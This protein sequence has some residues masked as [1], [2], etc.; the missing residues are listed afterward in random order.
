MGAHSGSDIVNNGLVFY[1]DMN[2]STK[3][4]KGQPTTN[5][6]PSPGTNGRFTT[7][8]TW[9]TYNTGLY[10][11][12]AYFSIGTIA[13]V[14]NN[15][16]TTTTPHIFNTFDAVLPETTGGGVTAGTVY[17]VKKISDTEF[18]LHAYNSSQD[19]S[20]GYINP[21]TG[22][23][24]VH[25]SIALDQRIAVNATSFPTSWW[26]SA[27]LPNTCHVKEV[28]EGG[29]YEKNTNCMRI[30]VTRTQNISG[31]MS[32]GVNT[33]ATAGDNIFVSFWARSNITTSIGYT[34]YFGPGNSTFG[35]TFN[36]SP[37]WQKIVFNWTASATYDFI[38]YF[39]PTLDSTPYYIDIADIQVEKNVQTASPFT[40]NTRSN[41]QAI[42]DVSGQGNTATATS[43]TYNA[44]GTFSFN[45]SSN[46]IST[47]FSSTSIYAIDFWMYN[48]NAIIGDQSIGGPSTYQSPINF[49]NTSTAG[50]NLGGWTGS[51]TQEKLHIW[52]NN[53]VNGAGST[54]TQDEV[55]AGW[56]H[57]VFN[58]NG[59]TYDIWMDGIKRNTYA[60]AT[61]GHAKL[62]QNITVLRAGADAST[63]YYFHGELPAVKLYS[64]P[65]TDTEVLQNFNATRSLY[66]I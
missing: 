1:Y 20:Q 38:Q 57:V 59:S 26:G 12:G 11:G 9:G 29:G 21:A 39:F 41:T 2:N 5:Y 42:L 8:N 54:Y 52:S 3:S 23:H 4:W 31:G 36:V 15:V 49:N 37:E 61:N 6:L 30:H 60:H 50:V 19:G 35:N 65:L 34:T 7:A 44:D 13:S 62:L 51:M 58:W 63:G 10:N 25:D 18:T 53:T 22:M 43:L 66:G 27:H 14:T 16:I 56:H 24:K 64:S 48:N 40:L 32:Y 55:P 33:P 28:V 47:S 46:Y 17:F 45:G